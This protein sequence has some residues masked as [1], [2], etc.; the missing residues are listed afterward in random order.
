MRSRLIVVP[1]LVL[2]ALLVG[3][4]GSKGTGTTPTPEPTTPSASPTPDAMS[5]LSRLAGLGAKL[6]YSGAYSVTGTTPGTSRVVRTPSAYRF[7]LTTGKKPNLHRAVLIGTRTGTVSCTT[8]PSPTTCLTVAG[9]GKPPPSPFDAGLQHV[10]TDYLTT[11]AAGGSE[12]DVQTA[13]AGAGDFACFD[14]KP[15]ATPAPSNAVAAGTY[16]FTAAGVVSRVVYGTGQV[17]FQRFGAKPSPADF[18]PP[19]TPQPLPKS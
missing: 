16:C 14:V 6:S 2:V 13:V 4:N 8:A 9:P 12:Y 10:F 15:L 11:L 5:E 17:I 19:V 7:E 18:K 1:P 3:C